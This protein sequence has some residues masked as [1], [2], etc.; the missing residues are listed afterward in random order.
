MRNITSSYINSIYGF[1]HVIIDFLQSTTYWMLCR[2]TV[3]I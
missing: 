3:T 2:A 1:L